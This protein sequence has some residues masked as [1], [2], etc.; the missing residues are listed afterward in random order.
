[1]IKLFKIREVLKQ[2]FGIDAHYRNVGFFP[3]PDDNVNTKEAGL[4]NLFIHYSI[5]PG[6]MSVPS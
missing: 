3:P 5:M 1:M 6:T 2:V 4:F